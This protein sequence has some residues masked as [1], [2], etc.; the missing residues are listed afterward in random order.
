M[1]VPRASIAVLTA[2]VLAGC[3]SRSVE[4]KPL[5][6]LVGMNLRAAEE[7]L[8]SRGLDHDAIGGGS[9]GIIVRSNWRVCRQDPVAGKT[10]KGVTVY[11][12]RRCTAGMPD[13]RRLSLEDAD[14][15]LERAGVE[16][17]AETPDGDPVIVKRLWRVCD[18]ERES[19]RSVSLYVDRECSGWPE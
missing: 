16:W 11:V 4:S 7:T 14:D 1:N 17:T 9:F 13:V 6:D 18:Q 10:A 15:E 19:A 8:D 3:G 12:A 2:L 5:P